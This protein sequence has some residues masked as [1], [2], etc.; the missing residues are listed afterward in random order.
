MSYSASGNCC[1]LNKLLIVESRVV[2]GGT[3]NSSK[4]AKVVFLVFLTLGVCSNGNSQAVI[5]TVGLDLHAPDS[6]YVE[7]NGNWLT[8]G[9]YLPHDSLTSAV[10]SKFLGNWYSNDPEIAP[11]D[12]FG[13][14][15]GDIDRTLRVEK[16]DVRRDT[17][18]YEPSIRM[19]A[20]VIDK[21]DN[22]RKRFDI[23]SDV[24]SPGDTIRLTLVGEDTGD[25]L[26]TG[27]NLVF[28]EGAVDTSL[29]GGP[30]YF[31]VDLQTFEGFHVWRGLT[32]YPTEMMVVEDISREDAFRGVDEDSLYFMEWPRMDD[33]GRPYYEW[34]DENVFVGFTYYY[35]VSTYDRGYFKGQFLYNKLDN[36]ICD[37]E[38]T[39]DP[40]SNPDLP[41]CAVAVD[42][43][44]V[45]KMV[46]ISV[47]PQAEMQRIYAV[48]NPFRTGTSAVTSPYYHN[49]P[50]NSIKF[51]N[52][53]SEADLR[54]YTVS[55][56]LVWE[57]HHSSMDG[58]EGVLTWNTNN[59]H[60]QPA[61]SGVYIFRVESD[62]GDSMYGR[63]VIIR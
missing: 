20:E 5:D 38:C 36:F 17:V 49:F 35:Q 57:T 45:A 16:E 11:V 31:E 32:P 21:F 61:G 62:S 7:F 10:G 33:Q 55:G 6:V 26:E 27:V 13:F 3:V 58:A 15:P 59:K 9:W 40:L 8:I 42:C 30:A 41:D 47:P 44:D 19:V 48:P 1:P 52:M 12:I 4:A 39:T 29:L 24:Y 46:T 60:G 18:G 53:P 37:E 54:I 2:K 50:D 34:V 25:T 23:G 28:H 51:Y 43:E 63:I 56:D 14:Y 22:Y